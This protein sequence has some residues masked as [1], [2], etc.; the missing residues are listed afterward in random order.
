M[1]WNHL[2][3]AASAS[4]VALR[5][6]DV[7]FSTDGIL[8]SSRDIFLEGVILEKN[9][10]NRVLVLGNEIP[11]TP[12]G[13]YVFSPEKEQQQPAAPVARPGPP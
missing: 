7:L 3:I 8:C 5:N 4:R 2:E 9:G 11:C 6:T 12:Q 1:D 13:V 10:L